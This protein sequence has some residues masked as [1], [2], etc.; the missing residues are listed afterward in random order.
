M[1]K[2][3]LKACGME[4]QVRKVEQHICPSCDATIKPD[5]FKDELSKREYRISG[6][7]QS[8]QDSIFNVSEDTDK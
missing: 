3:I 7:C 8:C 6:L 5:E 4:E 1:N 2:D